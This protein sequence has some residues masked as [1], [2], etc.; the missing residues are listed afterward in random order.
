MRGRVRARRLF[1]RVR[2]TGRRVQCPVCGRS[3]SRFATYRG[4]PDAR[5]VHCDSVERDR[6]LWM[7]LRT[8]IPDGSRVLHVAPERGI[9][10]RLRERPIDYVTTDLAS[11]LASRHDD[12]T[13]LPDPDDSFDV[14]IC[15]H[16]LEHVEDDHAAISELR[17]VLRT[18][19]FAV[20]MH[21]IKRR[22]HTH[23]DPAVVSEE[24]RLR[25]FGQ[26][27]HVRA[28]GQDFYDRL[29]GGGFADVMKIDVT[30][31]MA[32]GESERFG[33]RRHPPI[34]VGR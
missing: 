5:C 3:A 34:I 11:P 17:R 9:T 2:Y 8:A 10:T 4:R 26:A 12:V 32:P 24:D 20:L 22:P 28:Y 15:N 23:E 25:V 7:W 6:A 30:E 18:D 21:P 31:G 29:R 16:V 13:A 33:V 1:E 27:D 14:V 19:G